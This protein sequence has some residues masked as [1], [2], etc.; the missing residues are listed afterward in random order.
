M[1]PLSIEIVISA[2]AIAVSLLSLFIQFFMIKKPKLKWIVFKNGST[3]S[4]KV[5]VGVL[6]KEKAVLNLHERI[7]VYKD[8]KWIQESLPKNTADMKSVSPGAVWTSYFPRGDLHS[9]PVEY[10]FRITADN[11]NKHYAK[12]KCFKDGRFTIEFHYNAWGV[13]RKKVRKYNKNDVEVWSLE[14]IYTK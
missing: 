3:G 5:Y 11:I 6:I 14:D 12:I 7:F 13:N 8:G 2:I 4:E 1:I 9:D 10:L